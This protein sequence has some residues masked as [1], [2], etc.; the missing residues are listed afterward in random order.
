MVKRILTVV[1]AS[2]AMMACGPGARIDGKQGA[3]E[4]LFAAS[5]PSKAK[6]DS[7][8]TPVDVTGG[9]SFKCPEGGTADISGAGISIGTGGVATSV[10]L[11]YNGCGLAKHD[12]YGVAI[13]NGDLTMAQKI[14]TGGATISVDQSFK[15]HV[16]VQGAYDD[17]L[18][19]DV[20]ESVAVGDLGTQG[21]GV[22][23]VLKGTIT[24][25]EGTFTFDE[26]ISVIGGN[27]SAKVEASR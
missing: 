12:K 5:A 8:A 7:S 18:D 10:K 21:S 14:V 13:F 4:A 1:V 26:M 25:K 11:T 19:V 2:F 23:I 22:S 17:F 20:S 6:A 27:I 16:L 9:L 3:A 15:G 24:D